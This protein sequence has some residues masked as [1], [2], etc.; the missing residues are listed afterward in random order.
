MEYIFLILG[1]IVGLTLSFIFKFREK[2]YGYIE[3]DHNNGLCRFKV[4]N[5]E[6][7]DKKVKK[8]LFVV[9]HE[10]KIPMYKMDD[11]MDDDFVG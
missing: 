11:F 4:T 2:T 3:I 10:G 7:A 5:G 9:N 6:L 8:V 1:I